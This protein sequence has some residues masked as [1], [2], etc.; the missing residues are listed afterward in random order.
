MRRIAVC[1]ALSTAACRDATPAVDVPVTLT[2]VPNVVACAAGERV[3]LTISGAPRSTAFDFALGADLVSLS[4]VD[5]AR[6]TAT[7]QCAAVGTTML[8][9]SAANSIVSVPI[10]VRAAAPGAI[11]VAVAPSAIA[12]TNGTSAWV[13]ARV[14]SSVAGASTDVRY[15]S[16]DTA[17]VVVDSISGQLRATGRGDALVFA[18]ARADRSARAATTVSVVPGGTLVSSLAIQ[19]ASLALVVGDTARVAAD[20]FLTAA[21]PPTTS[22]L[23][24]F[25]STDS[26]VLRV[27]ADGTVRALRAGSATIVVSAVAA[28]LIRGNVAVVVRVPGI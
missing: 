21:A 13:T 14:T 18:L 16:D 8:L 5:R 20:V 7:I 10:V 26:T 4:D 27:S 9:A 22:R 1:L 24:A 15:V 19:T 17:V 25:A 3:P 2:A 11:R 12:M 23:P 28:P 6:G